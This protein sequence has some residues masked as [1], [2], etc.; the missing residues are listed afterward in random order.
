MRICDLVI[1]LEKMSND[2]SYETHNL[3]NDIIFKVNSDDIKDAIENK[4]VILNGKVVLDKEAVTEVARELSTLGYNLGLAACVGSMTGGV[5]KVVIKS[6]IHPLQKAGLVLSVGIVDAVL[7]TGASAIN[8]QIHAEHSIDK[9][10]AYTNQSLLPKDVSIFVGFI[11][12]QTPLEILLQCIFVLNSISIWIITIF[13]IQKLFKLYIRD[14]PKLI[15]VYYISFI[16]SD[17]IIFYIYKLIKLIKNMNRFYFIC[18]IILLVI[19]IFGY[20]YFSWELYN[21][22]SNY[23]DVYIQYRKK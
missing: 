12:D 17:I 14:K 9:F 22:L 5:A 16:Y 21:N 4:D 3:L 7:Y 13:S 15:W 11:N 10:S 23:V 8:T 1:L 6:Y 2:N 20:A 19:C 18:A